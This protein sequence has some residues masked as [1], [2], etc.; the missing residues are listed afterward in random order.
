MIVPGEGPRY[1]GTT[2]E[3]APYDTAAM[4]AAR[5]RTMESG[6]VL[7]QPI[8]PTL[9]KLGPGDQLTVSIP[10]STFNQYD[11][12]VTP[13]AKIIIPRVGEVNLRGKTLAE[14]ERAIREAVA[15]VYNV[16]GASVSLRKIRQF[17]VSVIGAVNYP[18]TV[19]ASPATRVSEAIDIGGGASPKASK[20]A[21][22]IFRQGKTLDV[23][24]L[25]FYAFGDLTANPFIEGG[26]VIRVGVQDPKDV[27]TIYGAVQRPGEWSFREGDSI[28][29]LIRYSLGFTADAFLDS[30][31]V[32][33]VNGRGDTLSKE[34]FT[35]NMDGSIVGDRRLRRGD[36]IFVRRVQDF[37][38]TNEAVVAGE[39]R[40]PGTYPIE[41]G[42]TRLRDLIKSAGGFTTNASIPDAVLIRR[43]VLREKDTKY[44]LILQI[45][46]EKRT[47]E[48][49]SYLR[50][51]QAERPGVMTVDVMRLMDGAE[52]ENIVL[53]DEDSLF[54]PA[55]KDFIKVTGKVK[56]PGNV[57]FMTGASY[58]HYLDLAG[59]YG[60][61]ADKDETRI[62]KGNGD[63]FLASSEDNYE[64]EPGD[65]IFVPEEGESTFWES[66]TSAITI[67]AQ[68]GTI[69]AVILSVRS[70]VKE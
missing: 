30:V 6:L 32:V 20:R 2:G 65:A 43:R 1:P 49:I 14:G 9:Y 31:Q 63:T 66:F 70:S 42:Q 25:P 21:I 67:V 5:E 45:D 64:L 35:A 13:D 4:K 3:S 48:D 41:S 68:I 40:Y 55:K 50:V 36:R 69:V 38:N 29:S 56:N 51:K 54:V 33:S 27:V 8:D 44:D 53:A 24:L 60:W 62:I 12:P 57:T 28:S 7:E 17:K 39:M 59:G 52:S 16:G 15:R 11:L 10:T 47:P 23:D 22:T 61:R 19:T 26:D 58:E 34:F 37:L 18:G 46:P